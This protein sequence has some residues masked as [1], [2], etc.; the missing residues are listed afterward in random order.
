MQTIYNN[1]GSS[2]NEAQGELKGTNGMMANG[3]FW[4][5][6]HSEQMVLK[7]VSQGGWTT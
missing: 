2:S 5:L 7:A 4:D 1:Q 6:V 3:D